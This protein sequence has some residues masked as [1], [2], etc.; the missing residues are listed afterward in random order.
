MHVDLP[1][2]AELNGWRITVAPSP[3]PKNGKA[4]KKAVER[5]LRAPAWSTNPS[6][7]E[8]ILMRG[9][10]KSPWETHD[11]KVKMLDWSVARG[12]R[13]AYTCRLCGRRFCRFT[14]STQGTWA[15]D[16]EARAL[17]DAVT[18]RWLS[19]NCPRLYQ[20]SDDKDRECLREAAAQ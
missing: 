3:A 1:G 17:D 12:S 10:Q 19:E 15:V 20:A 5:Q 2:N 13:L 4:Q 11:F 18:H 14:V 16:G 8:R 6:R 9:I 7:L